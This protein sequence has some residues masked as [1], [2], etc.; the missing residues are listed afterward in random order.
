MLNKKDIDVIKTCLKM[1][2]AFGNEKSKNDIEEA[3]RN[4]ICGVEHEINWYRIRFERYREVLKI[5]ATTSI[6][7]VSVDLANKTL[8]KEFNVVENEPCKYCRSIDN[9]TKSSPRKKY[10]FCPM[11]GRIRDWE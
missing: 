11:C 10:K 4:F 9:A 6:D 7:N 3:E 1:M 5:I 8:Y 2:K